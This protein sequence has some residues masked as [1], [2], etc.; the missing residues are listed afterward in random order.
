MHLACLIQGVSNIACDVEAKS[1]KVT[2]TIGHEKILAKM[3]KWGKAS[4]KEVR[5]IGVAA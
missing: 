4:D 2:A 5:Y 3:E 1:V